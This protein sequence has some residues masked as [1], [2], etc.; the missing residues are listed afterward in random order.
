MRIPG[1][2]PAR[3]G[4]RMRFLHSSPLQNWTHGWGMFGWDSPRSLPAPAALPVPRI[5]H[6][7]RSGPLDPVSPDPPP[8]HDRRGAHERPSPGHAPINHARIGTTP[9]NDDIL[10]V[11]HAHGFP[12]ISRPRPSPSPSFP[13]PATPPAKVTPPLNTPQSHRCA[14]RR[15]RPKPRPSVGLRPSPLPLPCPGHTLD[16]DRAHLTAKPFTR[17]RPFPAPRPL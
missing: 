9:I 15:P 7:P 13:L 5:L 1:D 10:P 6:R 17:P 12:P 2:P 11:D 8:G 16:S 14:R 4:Y 3:H